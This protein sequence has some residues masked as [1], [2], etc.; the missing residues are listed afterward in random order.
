M[1]KCLCHLVIF[2]AFFLVLTNGTVDAQSI[3]QSVIAGGGRTSSDTNSAYSVTGTVGQSAADASSGT[4]YAIKSGF[5]TA[6]PISPTAATVTVSGKITTAN[7]RGIRNVS[8]VMT[9][10]SGTVR[11]TTST[12]FGHFHFTD[13]MPGG[14]YIFSAHAKRFTFNQAMQVRSVVE[15]I[16][17]INFVADESNL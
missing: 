6:A 7:G 1:N 15:E 17:D 10:A 3:E 11:R 12:M 9:D 2:A 5:L 13:V 16:S 14:T 4:P 8:V